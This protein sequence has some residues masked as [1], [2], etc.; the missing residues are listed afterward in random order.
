[1]YKIFSGYTYSANDG[2]Q[3]TYEGKPLELLAYSRACSVMNY[4]SPDGG[5][6]DPYGKVNYYMSNYNKGIVQSWADPYKDYREGVE[7]C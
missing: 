6:P 2:Y 3:D 1:M 7:T 4:W 5:C